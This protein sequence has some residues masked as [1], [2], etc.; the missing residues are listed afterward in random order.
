MDFALSYDDVLLLPSYSDALPYEIDT[1]IELAPNLKLHIPILSAAMDTVT[2]SHMAAAI[3]LNGGAGVIHRNLSVADQVRAVAHVKESL[4]W[5]IY[6]PITINTKETVGQARNIMETRSIGGLPIVENDILRGI[7]TKRDLIVA[8]DASQQVQ[9]LMIPNPVCYEGENPSFD[10]MQDLFHKS[11][12]GR[13]PLV[14]KNNRLIGL[15]CINDFHKKQLDNYPNPAIDKDG[16]LIV[17]AAVSPHGYLERTEAMINA[18]VNFIVVDTAHGDSLNV[19]NTV[20][21]LRKTYPD[22]VIVGGNVATAEGTEHLIKAGADLVKVG[23]G[24]GAICTTRVV[25]G[26]GVPQFTAVKNCAEQAEKMG[27]KVIADGGIRTSGDITKAIGIGACMVM[28]GNMLSGLEETPGKFFNSGGKLYKIYRGMGSVGAIAEGSG[29][30]YQFSTGESI[31][32]EGVESR[33][34]YKGELRPYL[35]QLVTGLKKGMGY[36]GCKTLKDLMTYKKFI[37]I[38]HAGIIESR[39]HD[40]DEIT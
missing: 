31:V 17:G 13:I 26:M 24:P 5:I 12:V 22:L 14:D 34:P 39:V 7:I 32:P 1:S 28:L 3:A 8:Q 36:C 38:T 23:M 20:K 37:R 18:G 27:K 40:V 29:D 9:D 19:I 2:E 33:V 4:S 16:K 11:R 10:E 35:Y 21:D 25:S 6:N 30:R 15:V